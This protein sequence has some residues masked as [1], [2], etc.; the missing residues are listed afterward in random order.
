MT[1][2]LSKIGKAAKAI[3]KATAKAPVKT[4][5]TAD[6][7]T[8]YELP[9]GSIVDNL[10]PSQV[11]MSWPS[12]QEFMSDMEGTAFEA[13]DELGQR[14]ATTESIG[15]PTQERLMENIT[16]FGEDDISNF[17]K[18]RREQLID[19]ER[20][21]NIKLV[22]GQEEDMAAGGALKKTIK[23]AQKVGEKSA[24]Q[25]ALN[26]ARGIAK[27]SFVRPS[28]EKG[29]VYHGTNKDITKFKRTL[30]PDDHVPG[31][32]VTDDPASASLYAEDKAMKQTGGEGA[33][34]LPLLVRTEKPM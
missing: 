21:A 1:G 33:N 10:K 5:K 14:R 29:V 19:Q 32:S 4:F 15:V 17:Y 16:Q 27:E 25:E 23:A 34:V 13:G 2:P 20:K 28:Q 18:A 30:T 12:R 11:D 22:P 8:F 6:G 26:M 9:N 31:I 24:R 7:Y 3:K